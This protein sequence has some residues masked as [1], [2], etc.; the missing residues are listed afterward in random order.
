MKCDD[1]F[2]TGCKKPAAYKHTREDTLKQDDPE[3]LCEECFMR[4]EDDEK[5]NP[6]EWVK[7]IC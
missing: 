6:D 3:Y 4:M 5:F 2:W 1:P 7:M